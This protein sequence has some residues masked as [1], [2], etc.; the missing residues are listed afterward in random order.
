MR[1]N[2][3]H[4][5]AARPRRCTDRE[6]GPA[7]IRK[8]FTLIELLVVVAII[9]LLVSIL[10]PSLVMAKDLAK[11]AV[12]I[13]NLHNMGNL[14]HAYTSEGDGTVPLYIT[15]EPGGLFYTSNGTTIAGYNVGWMDLML[16]KDLTPGLFN[17]PAKFCP[18][19]QYN[20]SFSSYI[21]L[22]SDYPLAQAAYRNYAYNSYFGFGGVL[23]KKPKVEEIER[24]AEIVVA[25]DG[26]LDG[27]EVYGYINSEQLVNEYIRRVDKDSIYGE[28][29]FPHENHDGLQILL[30]DGH[31]EW[32]PWHDGDMGPGSIY[33]L[34]TW[35]WWLER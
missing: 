8:A 20:G 13:S 4:V 14:F 19:P 24:A 16:N 32:R 2:A 25:A 34:S 23:G 27:G 1:A 12:C 15:T 11:R 33:H 31:A 30:A 6:Q 10:I 29:A 21:P 3:R 7:E 22:P 26:R 18:E 5:W 9:S 17:C 35:Q 28:W